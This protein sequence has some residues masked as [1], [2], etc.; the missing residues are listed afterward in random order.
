MSFIDMDDLAAHAINKTED[1]MQGEL[2]EEKQSFGSSALR[3]VITLIWFVVCGIVSVAAFYAMAAGETAHMFGHEK[4]RML[5]ILGIVVCLLIFLIT[6]I[7]PYLRK[8]GTMTRWLG[9][10][11]LGDALWLA[12]LLITA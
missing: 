8:K 2:K 7:V 11:A 5:S 12:Y 9:I 3:F 4:G 10:C 1:K 6:F